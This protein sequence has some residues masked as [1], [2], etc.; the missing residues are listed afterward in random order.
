MADRRRRGD[1]ADYFGETANRKARIM[2]GLHCAVR[3]LVEPQ[4][5]G[6]FSAWG[7][8]QRQRLPQ[9]R[10][11][12]ITWR[13][14]NN[15][16]GSV[17]LGGPTRDEREKPFADTG[18][19]RSIVRRAC[20]AIHVTDRS[21]TDRSQDADALRITSSPNPCSRE[22]GSASYDA[23]RIGA[24]V[25]A[26]PGSLQRGRQP[27]PVSRRPAQACRQKKSACPEGLAP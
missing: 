23:P 19:L 21:P 9:A 26:R 6:Q 3:C 13:K 27:E 22:H 24:S 25:A 8:T 2:D 14:S 20:G 5:A 4:L 15:I 1:D 12:V 11:T 18:T 16:F 17:L 7:Q 10:K